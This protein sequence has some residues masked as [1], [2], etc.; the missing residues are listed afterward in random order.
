VS[1]CSFCHKDVED[2][3]TQLIDFDGV[4]LVACDVCIEQGEEAAR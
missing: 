4:L 2:D 1:T 3:L